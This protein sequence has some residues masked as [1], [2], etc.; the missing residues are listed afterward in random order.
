MGVKL[1]EFAGGKRG[2][3]HQR[4]AGAIVGGDHDAAGIGPQQPQH[5]VEQHRL[6]AARAADQGDEAALG[7]LQ[8][9]AAKNGLAIECLGQTLDPDFGSGFRFHVRFKIHRESAMKKQKRRLGCEPPPS[10]TGVGAFYFF[11]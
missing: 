1:G 3:V 10:I 2:D 9:T 11:R 5:V 4:R 7:D 8:I 6:A